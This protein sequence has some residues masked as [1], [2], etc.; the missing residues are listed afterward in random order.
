M[1]LHP[2]IDAEIFALRPDFMALSIHV[3]GGRNGPS[4]A[5]SEALLAEQTRYSERMQIARELHDLMGHHLTALNLHLQLGDALLA[6]ADRD[7]AA[8]AVG[9]IAVDVDALGV[10]LLSM[11]AHKL[12]GPKGIGALYSRAAAAKRLLEPLYYGGGQEQGLRSG[13]SNVPCIVGFGE[14]CAIAQE[15]LPTE[16]ASVTGL[17][18]LLEQEL[19]RAIPNASIN[20]QK[21]L[22]LPNTSSIILPGI[23]NDA[24]LLNLP[25]IMIAVGSA[26][27]S[28]AI[29]PSHVLEAIGLAR[30]MA[31]STVRISLGRFTNEREIAETAGKIIAEV[32]L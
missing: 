11:S 13:T 23:D 7:G 9:K 5:T 26:C 24:L 29:E 8:Q 2:I 18:D 25:N 4:D 22:R 31:Y 32:L 6:R 15:L 3:S 16:S 17:R 28:G 14:A 12:Y 30:G 21:A 20:A 19:V 10:D 27:N 1:T